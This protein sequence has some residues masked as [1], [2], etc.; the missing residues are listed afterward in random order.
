MQQMH[1]MPTRIRSAMGSQMCTRSNNA[2][3]KLLHYPDVLGRTSQISEA[4]IHRLSIIHKKASQTNFQKFLRQIRKEN[5]LLLEKEQQK[6]H[7]EKIRI[8]VFV[9]GE[10]GDKQKRPHW[11]ALIFNWRPQDATYL[12]SNDRGDQVF[13]S[14]T[15]HTLGKG[16]N[17]ARLCYFRISRLLR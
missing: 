8:S 17:R 14:N 16:Q 6:E 15:R 13:T 2:R 11:H 5:W 3:R 12:Y 1:R 10:Y 9:T 4:S 7:L